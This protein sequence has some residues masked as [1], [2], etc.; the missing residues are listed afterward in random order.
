MDVIGM[1]KTQ[2]E[3]R[4][5][6]ELPERKQFLRRYFGINDSHHAR[7]YLTTSWMRPERPDTSDNFVKGTIA[8]VVNAELVMESFWAVDADADCHRDIGQKIDPVSID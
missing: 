2:I 7:K 5:I 6:E 8:I 3:A 1:G 4:Y